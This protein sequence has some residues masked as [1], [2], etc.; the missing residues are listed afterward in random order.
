[1]VILEFRSQSKHDHGREQS[2]YYFNS[3]FN[4]VDVFFIS[5]SFA[6]QLIRYPRTTSSNLEFPNRRIHHRV[7]VKRNATF[8][9]S[10]LNLYGCHHELLSP[11]ELSMVWQIA[12]TFPK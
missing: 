12:D 3:Q 5:C 4:T 7:K 8:K 10:L 2:N 1:M 9:L 6:S 11:R